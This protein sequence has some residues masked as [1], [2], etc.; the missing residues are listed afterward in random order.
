MDVRIW[1]FA[2][3]VEFNGTYT[4]LWNIS[5]LALLDYIASRILIHQLLKRVC[6]KGKPS[7]SLTHFA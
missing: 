3:F 4:I 1:Y 7:A 2:G 5:G 6:L